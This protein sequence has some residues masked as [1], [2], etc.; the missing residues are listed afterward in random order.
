MRKIVVSNAVL[1]LVVCAGCAP[2]KVYLNPDGTPAKPP[3]AAASAGPST[4]EVVAETALGVLSGV[5]N[6]MAAPQRQ[7]RMR[8]W[9]AANA[10]S[11]AKCLHPSGSS[12]GKFQVLN[13]NYSIPGGTM[14]ARLFWSGAFGFGLGEHETDISITASGDGSPASVAVAVAYDGGNFGFDKGCDYLRGA[15]M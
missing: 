14:T 2:E 3:P 11:I 4:G 12:K 1:F 8:S 10:A 7:N 5:A 9:L 13:E 6:G 15:T